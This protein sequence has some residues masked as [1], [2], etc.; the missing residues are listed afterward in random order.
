ML[1]LKNQEI[2]LGQLEA[3][4][5]NQARAPVKLDDVFFDLIDIVQFFEKS[6]RFILIGGKG[7]GKSAFAITYR[8]RANSHYNK[9]CEIVT[10][11]ALNFERILQAIPSVIDT[12]V[13]KR[14]LQVA[15]IE[16]FALNSILKILQTNE[17][18][19]KMPEYNRIEEYFI[20]NR[21]MVN[22]NQGEFVEATSHFEGQVATGA[23][24]KFIQ[25]NFKKKLSFKHQ[26]ANF[27]K[28][29]PDLKSCIQ[30]ILARIS[31][32][33][34]EEFYYTIIMDDLDHD[35]K[36]IPEH[37]DLLID[38]IRVS[39]DFNLKL[40][41]EGSENV[42]VKIVL[43]VRP[44][45][46][47]ELGEYTDA[48][49]VVESYKLNINWYSTND[50]ERD[51]ALRKMVNER[52]K[53]VLKN[54]GNKKISADPWY[55]LVD[56]NSESEKDSFK[57][58]LDRTRYRPRDIILLLNKIISRLKKDE[59]I[60]MVKIQNAQESYSESFWQEIKNELSF[61]LNTKQFV[62]LEKILSSLVY[63][64]NYEEFV[65]KYSDASFDCI[66]PKR[67]LEILFNASVLGNKIEK[68][69]QFKSRE[70]DLPIW[71]NYDE[72]FILNNGLYPKFRRPGYD[73]NTKC[74]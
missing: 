72:Q 25:A 29:I 57:Y 18:V 30:L 48:L 23:L 7:S 24:S 66:D 15:L 63:P 32:K 65:E 49:K 52:I 37:R 44:D 71:I 14:E 43:L 8:D 38:L 61:Y 3:E 47:T 33:E 6:N 16:W 19:K 73:R 41:E 1:G 69:I 45:L 59:K 27:I 50:S 12:S 55:D 34:D 56:K 28:L 46:I 10:K 42:F 2:V 5:E 51:T 67:L 70:F 60:S 20:I 58:C 17:R 53:V 64:F 13:S 22:V 40:V 74:H 26:K 11:N 9:R 35:F 4:A 39:K 62:S 31:E 36:N 68:V 21:G 54:L